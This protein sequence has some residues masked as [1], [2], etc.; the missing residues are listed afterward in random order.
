[1]KLF[2]PLFLCLMMFGC[3]SQQRKCE[4]FVKKYPDCFSK[5][6]S[7][8]I[9]ETPEQEIKLVLQPYIDTNAMNHLLD[10][11]YQI[12]TCISVVEIKE[13]IGK[14]PLKIKP[15]R[16]ETDKYIVNAR[17]GQGKILVDVVIKKQIDTLYVPH[18]KPSFNPKPKEPTWREKLVDRGIWFL[19]GAGIIAL[20]C[21]FKRR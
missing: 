1:M 4:K 9:K 20:V 10:S 16:E 7:K 3:M 19:F 6:T 14:I 21:I 17:I 11:L 15:Y 2:L 18:T 12:D 13:A 5:D 8:V